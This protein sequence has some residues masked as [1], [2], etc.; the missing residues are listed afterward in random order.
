MQRGPRIKYG[1]RVAFD[2]GEGQG[3]VDRSWQ[4]TEKVTPEGALLYPYMLM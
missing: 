1:K 3:A 4:V 2:F